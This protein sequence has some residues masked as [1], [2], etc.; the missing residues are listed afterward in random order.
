MNINKSLTDEFVISF[1]DGFRKDMSEVKAD[2]RTIKDAGAEQKTGLAVLAT[3]FESHIETDVAVAKTREELEKKHHDE[4]TRIYTIFGI[5][6]AIAIFVLGYFTNN[7]T[8]NLTNEQKQPI[9]HSERSKGDFKSNQ[10][11]R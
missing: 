9:I 3:L 1:M 8:N 10:G 11:I 4:K 7:V 6:V 5:V 2:V